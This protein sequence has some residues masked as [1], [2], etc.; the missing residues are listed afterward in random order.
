MPNNPFKELEDLY[1]VV[2]IP[3]KEEYDP[4]LG[5]PGPWQEYHKKLKTDRLFRIQEKAL[6]GED[7]SKDIPVARGIGK[8]SLEYMLK[9]ITQTPFN[10]VN[11]IISF[12]KMIGL[13][14]AFDAIGLKG[15]SEAFADYVK[16]GQDFYDTDKQMPADMLGTFTKDLTSAFASSA[17]YMI[18][19][20]GAGKLSKA[21]KLSPIFSSLVTQSVPSVLEAMQNA[22]QTYEEALG[23][24][25]SEHDATV[26][27]H[28]V[29][30]GNLP[31]NFF[32][33]KISYFGKNGK[34]ADKLLTAFLSEGGQ[35]ASQ[36][37]LQNL[38]LKDP[39][40]SGVLYSG[41]IGGLVGGMT[42]GALIKSNLIN[43]AKEEIN[44]SN[45]NRHF[46]TLLDASNK[47][48]PELIPTLIT[49]RERMDE[50]KYDNAKLLMDGVT[51]DIIKAFDQQKAEPKALE[52]PTPSDQR[53]EK[54]MGLKQIQG[55]NETQRLM[56]YKIADTKTEEYKPDNPNIIILVENGL[57]KVSTYEGKVGRDFLEITPKGADYMLF[58]HEVTKEEFVKN[59]VNVGEILPSTSMS[60]FTEEAFSESGIIEYIKKPVDGKAFIQKE[61]LTR[62]RNEIDTGYGE[63]VDF[64]TYRTGQGKPVGML[65]ITTNLKTGDFE[66]VLDTHPDY[67][68]RGVA[69][70]MLNYA[71]TNGYPKVREGTKP[72]TPEGSL[73]KH[74]ELVREAYQAGEY[75]PKS[76]MDQYPNIAKERTFPDIKAIQI[77][78]IEKNTILENYEIYYRAT[79]RPYNEKFMESGLDVTRDL[80]LAHLYTGDYRAIEKLYISKKA[81]I[82]RWENLNTVAKFHIANKHYDEASQSAINQAKKEG[83]D[84]V[85]MVPTGYGTDTPSGTHFVARVGFQHIE[86]KRGK[87]QLVI[88]PEIIKTLSDLYKPNIKAAEFFIKSTEK[89]LSRDIS[90]AFDFTQK[91]LGKTISQ[92]Y[93]ETYANIKKELGDVQVNEMI[94]ED[95]ELYKK[96]IAPVFAKRPEL[97][98]QIEQIIVSKL[99]LM[100]QTTYAAVNLDT[101]HMTSHAHMLSVLQDMFYRN[102]DIF[103]DSLDV[104]NKIDTR[105][106]A[107]IINERFLKAGKAEEILVHEAAHNIEWQRITGFKQYMQS[108]L[109]TP[110]GIEEFISLTDEHRLDKP[111]EIFASTWT[112]W[113]TNPERFGKIYPELVE[114]FELV[115]RQIDF[116]SIRETVRSKYEDLNALAMSEEQMK[117]MQQAEFLQSKIDEEAGKV[118]GTSITSPTQIAIQRITEISDEYKT[119]LSQNIPADK[120]AEIETLKRTEINDLITSFREQLSPEEFNEVMVSASNILTEKARTP[121]DAVAEK[122]AISQPI[123]TKIEEKT[124][125]DYFTE[126]EIKKYQEKYGEQEWLDLVNAGIDLINENRNKPYLSIMHGTR[127]NNIFSI[128]NLGLKTQKTNWIKDAKTGISLTD[129]VDTA[130]DFA[131]NLK[132]DYENATVL[133]IKIP[134]AFYNNLR[135]DPNYYGGIIYTQNIPKEWITSINYYNEKGAITRVED[136][137][138]KKEQVNITPFLE[139]KKESTFIPPLNESEQIAYAKKFWTLPGSLRPDVSD[140]AVKLA[141]SKLDLAQYKRAIISAQ[142][143]EEIRQLVDGIKSYAAGT[144]EPTVKRWAQNKV[145]QYAKAKDKITFLKDMRDELASKFVTPGTEKWINMEITHKANDAFINLLDAVQGYDSANPIV[146]E[147]KPEAKTE[148]SQKKRESLI[149]EAKKEVLKL[150]IPKVEKVEPIVEMNI[151]EAQD[152]V[153]EMDRRKKLD[154]MVLGEH[155]PE[156]RS[157]V[158]TPENK[159]TGLVGFLKKGYDIFEQTFRKEGKGVNQKI[160]EILNYAFQVYHLDEANYKRSL[161]EYAANVNKEDHRM[162]ID[163]LRGGKILHAR[164]QWLVDEARKFLDLQYKEVVKVQTLFGR[165]VDKLAR[166]VQNYLPG[167]YKEFEGLFNILQYKHKSV[168]DFVDAIS[169]GLTPEQNLFEYLYR[170]YTNLIK[171][172]TKLSIQKQLLMLGPDVVL[173]SRNVPEKILISRMHFKYLNSAGL[174]HLAM[175][176]KDARFMDNVISPYESKTWGQRVFKDM[177][178][179]MRTSIFM[180]F[181]VHAKNI[182]SHAVLAIKVTDMPRFV[183]DSMKLIGDALDGSIENNEDFKEF[184]ARLGTERGVTLSQTVNQ[185]VDD[186][187]THHKLLSTKL[188]NLFNITRPDK[189]IREYYRM[190]KDVLWKYDAVLKYGLW[191][192][193]KSKGLSPDEAYRK[194]TVFSG[195]YNNLTRTEK[196]ITSV[197][198]FY[199]WMKINAKIIKEVVSH[200]I[201]YRVAFVNGLLM[202]GLFQLLTDLIRMWTNNKYGFKKPGVVGYIEDIIHDPRNYAIWHIRPEIRG[203]IEFTTGR[204]FGW[205]GKIK[206]YEALLRTV[207][208]LGIAEQAIFTNRDTFKSE[209][210]RM[211]GATL[212]R[213]RTSKVFDKYFRKYFQGEK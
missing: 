206:W 4:I 51:Q 125:K 70:A 43:D 200:P 152:F 44:Q 155:I 21:L 35:E 85:D 74:A 32:T 116:F 174:R 186:L 191:N 61:V 22:G 108:K 18:P 27:G 81:K 212:K 101:A 179:F 48:A 213:G 143:N 148:E 177:S 78:E 199:P 12:N 47:F 57:A 14:K 122:A 171:L 66:V 187:T 144:V 126:E 105:K 106:S 97:K 134:Q 154:E 117:K 15:V 91:A 131:I 8:W 86:G 138:I 60:I 162:I 180:N 175:S 96:Y 178:D 156:L 6:I 141:G 195:D 145:D 33:N 88:N 5:P 20:I 53:V 10:F 49:A 98:K 95:H 153:R 130:T 118:K 83:Y 160:K 75:I 135:P 17:T 208:P 113:K 2:P 128:K 182:T 34:V 121:I 94:T 11:D 136:I 26:A 93:T 149:S 164:H 192:Y 188:G 157:D 68:R 19:G 69:D 146:K 99:P 40:M 204:G 159:P 120:R 197:I 115:D 189:M 90:V 16:S 158:W 170:P 46:E 65:A 190:N 36:Q 89:S 59:Y 210:M 176:E 119:L 38:A 45:I 64:F 201:Q 55:L 185:V 163:S 56:L 71:E 129:D 67:R 140:I 30:W 79:R 77:S 102:A 87:E 103:N 100:G 73:R 168:S 107:V 42:E 198:L 110:D 161:I 52:L 112:L 13:N 169:R 151:S 82:L 7:Y 1:G 132:E 124:I 92:A 139:P 63:K 72:Y 76:V 54:L 196:S 167:L 114:K 181:T 109:L 31:I 203:A 24:G 3:E 37:F 184:E 183:M 142:T 209:G 137:E 202:F 211:L 172:R 29:F 193:L 166:Y 58:P 39:L 133:N 173:N 62:Q 207:A 127:I 23:R 150:E 80:E 123:P 205:P 41:L 84:I 194:M 25:M 147:T 165:D 104:W 28:K 9:P 50:G 111:E